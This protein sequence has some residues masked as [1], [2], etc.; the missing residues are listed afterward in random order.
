[1][2][3]QPETIDTSDV[4]ESDQMNED[5]KVNG[6]HVVG[7]V[8]LICMNVF[9]SRYLIGGF[10]YPMMQAKLGWE[11]AEVTAVHS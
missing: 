1:M 8:A 2:V 4:T 11:S 9:A 6:C 5:F 10:I 7:F 3:V